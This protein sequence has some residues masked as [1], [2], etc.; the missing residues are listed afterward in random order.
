MLRELSRD[1][2]EEQSP[3]PAGPPLKF[4]VASA[5][6][7]KPAGAMML[8][9]MFQRIMSRFILPGRAWLRQAWSQ[10]EPGGRF[11]RLGT[12]AHTVTGTGLSE[13]RKRDYY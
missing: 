2:L 6:I 7:L 10:R 5:Q 12:S 9:R 11:Q 8:V 3:I 1:Q 4:Q 13:G